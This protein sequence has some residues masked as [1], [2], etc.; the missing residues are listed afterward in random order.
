MTFGLM[1][2]EQSFGNPNTSEPSTLLPPMTRGSTLKSQ[3]RSNRP[4]LRE[5]SRPQV[6]TLASFVRHLAEFAAIFKSSS[7]FTY[8]RKLDPGRFTKK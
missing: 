5:S 3:T 7:P 6:G 8:K 2:L 4:N 1:S